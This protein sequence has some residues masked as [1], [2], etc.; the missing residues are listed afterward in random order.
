M[1]LTKSAMQRKYFISRQRVMKETGGQM[2]H[3]ISL[4]HLHHQAFPEA[5]ILLNINEAQEH[6]Q[7]PIQPACIPV[8]Q[9]R[10]FRNKNNQLGASLNG[11]SMWRHFRSIKRP[12]RTRSRAQSKNFDIG[13]RSPMTSLNEGE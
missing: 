9:P 1:K 4:S 3:R 11:G 6:R 8:R 2:R 13:R 7:T 10:N 12:A 5:G